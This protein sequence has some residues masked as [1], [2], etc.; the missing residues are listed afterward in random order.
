VG[1]HPTELGFRKTSYNEVLNVGA[2]EGNVQIRITTDG[3]G[4][5][6]REEEVNHDYEYVVEVSREEP[7]TGSAAILGGAVSARPFLTNGRPLTCDKR[8]I[9]G[10]GGGGSPKPI[11][12]PRKLTSSLARFRLF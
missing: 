9:M 1:F 7:R 10:S 6:T 2:E 3:D 11:R 4:S 12:F 5:R 8:Q